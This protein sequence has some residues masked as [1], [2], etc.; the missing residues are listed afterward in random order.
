MAQQV[1]KPA[2]DREDVVSIPSLPWWVKDPVLPQAAVQVT[3]AAWIWHRYGCGLG[4]QLH[5]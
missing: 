3:D 4:W 5:L 1:K 2:S